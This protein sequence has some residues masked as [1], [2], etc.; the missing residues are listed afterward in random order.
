MQRSQTLA[1]PGRTFA[2]DKAPGHWLLA[3]LGK[4]VLR[5]GGVELTRQMLDALAI[6]PRDK[7]VELAP[8]IGHTAERV[9]SLNPASYIGVDRDSHAAS[10]LQHRLGRDGVRF[11]HG[12]AEDT[13]LPGEAATIVFGEAM[14]SMHP[15]A[16]KRRVVAEAWRVLKRGGKYGIHELCLVP[17][18]APQS[19][20]KAI[21][22]ELARAIHHLVAPLTQAEWRELLEAAGFTVTLVREAPMHLLEPRRV[23]QDE[24]L[25]R[26]LAIAGRMLVNPEARR[27]V[28]RMRAAFRSLS[29]S[30][31]AV[32]LVAEKRY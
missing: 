27:R 29:G 23:V 20:R 30:I 19:M 3:R 21:Q 5:P 16:V 28:L 14:M 11:V 13:G 24:G 18:D 32:T 17:D 10:S 25:G 4:R 8:G 2:D 26:A 22:A 15:D 7:V 6:G 9:L 1:I 31:R 12:T